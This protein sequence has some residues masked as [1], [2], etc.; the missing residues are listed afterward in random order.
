MKEFDSNVNIIGGGLIGS[1]TAYSLSKLG[2]TVSILEKKKSFKNNTF[3]DQRTIAISEGTKNFLNFI[4]IWSK[5]SHYCEEIKSIKVID[6]KLFNQLNFDNSRRNSSLGYIIKNKQLF[7]IIYSE[8]KQISNITIFNEINISDIQV[9]LEKIITNTNKV[10]VSSDLNIAADGK[11]SFVR[12]FYKTVSYNKN[13]KKSAL[14]LILNHSK[15]HNCTAFELFYKNGP[16]AILPMKKEKKSF[17]SSIVWTNNNKFINSLSEMDEDKL[18]SILN[19]ETQNCIGNIKKIISRQV[20]PISAHLNSRF[21]EKKTIF[22]GDAAHSFHP[23]A[24]QGWNLGMKD[25]YNL[26]KLVS[27]YKHLG[28]EIGNDFFCKKYHDENFFNAYRLFQVTDKLDSIFKINSPLFNLLRSS[29]IKIINNNTKL[30]NLISDF[31]MG[32]N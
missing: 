20:F 8:I 27:N 5:I 32:V 24:G 29:G 4:G 14:V 1:L 30:K 10:K 13:Y 9:N 25:I 3:K 19:K 6:R 23:I 11:N 15:N 28:I 18:I 22:I 2:Y 17:C 31:A 7:D 12:K 26:H 21:Y 16:L